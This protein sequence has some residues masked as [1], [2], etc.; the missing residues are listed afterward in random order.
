[1]QKV[2]GRLK[3]SKKYLL[4]FFLCKFWVK[5]PN[6]RTFRKWLSGLLKVDIDYENKR[7]SDLN[8]E[9]GTMAKRSCKGLPSYLLNWT[10]IMF[11]SF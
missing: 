4:R 11:Y 9:N 3:L 5:S 10:V 7:D 1:M 6:W 2:N 8:T